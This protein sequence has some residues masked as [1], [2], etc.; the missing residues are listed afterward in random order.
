MNNI[1][2]INSIN[3]YNEYH[4]HKICHLQTILDSL[5]QINP[6]RNYIYLAGD[7]SLDNK[8][9]LSNNKTQ[10]A[11]NDYQH[12]LEPALMKTDIAYHMNKILDG[13]D[14]CVINTAVEESTISCR[15]I[16][17][18]EQ[19]KFIKKN[20]TNNDILIVS[21]G[22]NDIALSPTLNT[23]WNMVILMY[24]NSIDTIKKG[25]HYA[26]G[27]NYFINMF[28]NEV[29]TYILKIIGNKRPIKI[30]VCMIY[31]PDEKLTGSWADRTLGYLGY[32]ENP[33]KLQEA[34]KQ[35]FIHSTSGIK[36]TGSKVIACP[37]YKILDGKNTLDYVAR[38]EPSNIGGS[39]IACEFVKLIYDL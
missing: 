15:N 3:F 31:F 8:Y 12:I 22:G 38:V 27:L 2:K 20:I 18:L 17:L 10:T 5:K 16:N 23:I 14:Y 4:G 33:K 11:T 24:I 37:L 34:I 30:I 26:W 21:I 13:S 39:K 7:S 1:T 32:N 25:P 9:W 29:T 6:H 35:I 28:K 36:I 19:D